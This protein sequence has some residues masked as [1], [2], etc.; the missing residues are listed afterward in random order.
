MTAQHCVLSLVHFV[1]SLSKQIT[2]INVNARALCM[3][4]T[5]SVIEQ[6]ASN[7]IEE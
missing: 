2:N 6:I 3:S 4:K 7:D 1:I 5:S